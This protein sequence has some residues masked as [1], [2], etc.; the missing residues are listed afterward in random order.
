[1]YKKEIAP[2]GLF[3][4]DGITKSPIDSSEEGY[5]N[6]YLQPNSIIFYLTEDN[7]PTICIKSAFKANDEI[8]FA[9]LSVPMLV[10]ERSIHPV[11]REGSKNLNIRN[12]DGILPD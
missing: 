8:K 5:G 9:T 12:G 7:S 6:F 1:M 4:E 10:I 3:V 11:F 2:Q